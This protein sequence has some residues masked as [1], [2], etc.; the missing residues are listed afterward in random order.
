MCPWN[1][2]VDLDLYV[3]ST[4]RGPRL[5]ALKKFA[6]TVLDILC[7]HI[8]RPSR[9]APHLR[10]S[11]V[12]HIVCATVCPLCFAVAGQHVRARETGED[13][14]VAQAVANLALSKARLSARVHG[15][16]VCTP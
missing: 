8:I 10:A 3:T 1:W 11:A 14:I 16:P 15:P 12:I 13:G 6:A 4:L 2:P 9:N 5:T 7:L